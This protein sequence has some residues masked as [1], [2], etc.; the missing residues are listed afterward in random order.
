MESISDQ[1]WLEANLNP[2]LPVARQL[3]IPDLP[4]EE[5]QLRFTGRTGQA[6]LQQAF[7]FYRFVLANMPERGIGH[8]RLLD[9]GGGWG[10]VLRFFLREFPPDQLVLADCLSDAIQCAR[11]LHSPF[12]TIHNGVYPPLPFPKRSVGLCYAFSVF[13]HLPERLCCDWLQYL[14]TLLH[15]GGRLIITTRGRAQI[16]YLESLERANAPHPRLPAAATIRQALE[17]GIFQ[18]FPVGGGG[19]LAEDLFG[20]TWIPKSWMEERYRSLGFSECSYFAEFTTV[21]QCGFLLT[22]S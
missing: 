12:T 7:D 21:D 18:H 9:F 22:S 13:S 4:P 20:E 10:R 2:A 14:A 15:P 6:N 16:D 19:E 5:V 8:Q 1:K 3:A 11:S 17:D